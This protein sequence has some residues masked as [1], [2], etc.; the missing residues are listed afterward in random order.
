MARNKFLPIKRRQALPDIYAGG[1]VKDILLHSR[2]GFLSLIGRKGFSTRWAGSAID[3]LQYLLSLQRDLDQPIYLIP[4]LI[5]FDRKP[6][7]DQ[8]DLTDIIFGSKQKPGHLAPAAFTATAI[9]VTDMFQ[10]GSHHIQS[11][12][13]FLQELFANEFFFDPDQSAAYQIRKT[14]KAFIDD[15]ILVPH[16][17][18]PDT[19]NLTS[20][21]FRKLHFYFGLL[22]SLFDAYK[23][24]LLYYDSL[25]ES[26][27]IKKDRIKSMRSL[28]QYMLK[29]N[30]LDH[31]ESISEAYFDQADAVFSKLGFQK[32]ESTAKREKYL[33]H[34]NCYL[35]H[36]S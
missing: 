33:R 35:K 14:I 36:S 30:Q 4:H 28:A 7:Q 17:S 31:V 13:E 2:A 11:D 32:P 22:K 9:L 26:F 29:K 34:I 1:F 8:Q 24:A 23:V 10:F 19:Y 18:L 5:F 27:P 15:A 20:P 3:P 21:G 12:Y 16:P 25:P 6:Y